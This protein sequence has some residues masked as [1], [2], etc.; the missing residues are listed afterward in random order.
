M[1]EWMGWRTLERNRE[2][3][4]RKLNFPDFSTSTIYYINRV[5]ELRQRK[6]TVTG[7]KEDISTSRANREIK[8]SQSID[9][10]THMNQTL[11]FQHIFL[12]CNHCRSFGDSIFQCRHVV[13]GTVCLRVFKEA[14][15]L[16]RLLIFQEI[17]SAQKI[18]K[19]EIARYFSCW[20]K[21]RIKLGWLQLLPTLC[22]LRVELKLNLILPKVG[23]KNPILICRL[24]L[25]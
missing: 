10:H 8:L 3:R 7:I 16:F 13:D 25:G 12:G 14:Q 18:E 23:K 11:Y 20:L 9:R 19:K 5:H 2:K 15:V 1:I 22:E 6:K 24:S 4:E 17:D 21:E